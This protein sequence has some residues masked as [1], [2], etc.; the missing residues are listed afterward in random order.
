MTANT[1]TVREGELLH[2]LRC[3]VADLEGLIPV[4]PAY[5]QEGDCWRSV[6]EAC[7]VISRVTGEEVLPQYDGHPE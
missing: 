1:M 7:E 6:Q 5:C 2:A 4:A 3:C